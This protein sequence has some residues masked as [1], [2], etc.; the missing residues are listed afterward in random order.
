MTDGSSSTSRPMLDVSSNFPS[1]LILP[2]PP[3]A[4][5]ERLHD[6]LP[7]MKAANETLD[8]QEKNDDE[9]L[10]LEP[11]DSDSDSS[12]VESSGDTDS[13]S[14]RESSLQKNEMDNED[15]EP[16]QKKTKSND[17]HSD[18]RQQ[19]CRDKSTEVPSIQSSTKYVGIEVLEEV[20]ND[21]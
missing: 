1:A 4:L 7:R 2:P 11:F 19:I 17:T 13:L 14:E 10:V 15:V 9:A 21:E 5:L 8:V 20:S 16:P 6:F 18:T 12:D 3:S